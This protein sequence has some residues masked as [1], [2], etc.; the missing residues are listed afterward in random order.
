[1]SQKR[2]VNKIEILGTE[3]IKI[4]ALE[5]LIRTKKGTLLD[6]LLIAQD[7]TRLNRL[8]SIASVSFEVDHHLGDLYIVKYHIVENFTLIPFGNIYT[9]T[10]DDFAFRVGVQEFNFT[11]NNTILSA[12]YQ[13]D[14]FHSYGIAIRAPYLFSRKWGLSANYKDLTTEEPVFLQNGTARY[15]Y[16]NTGFELLGLYELNFNNTLELGFSVFKEDYD[17]RSGSTAT[18]VPLELSVNKYLLKLLYNFEDITYHYYY[19]NGFRSQLNL[20]YVGSNDAN[21]LPFWI[22]FND[23]M[24]YKRT[25]LKGNFASRLRLGIASNQDTPFA[26]F[27]IDNNVNIRGVGNTIDRGTGA[28]V[29]NTEFRYTLWEKDWFVLQ[30]NSFIDVGTWRNP[31]GNLSDFTESK[32]LRIHPGMGLR[33]IHKRIYNAIIRIDYGHGITKNDSRGIVFGI[34]QYF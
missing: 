29:L 28:L 25:G 33:F 13:F 15:R 20:Q 30:G 16:N 27:S 10:N 34:G 1:M 24:Y 32:N 31:G 4:E 8:P 21:L 22:G 18:G 12:F 26:P 9:S 23:F 14:V 11:G 6:S 19:L 17:Y 2:M 5:K 7:I 3:R